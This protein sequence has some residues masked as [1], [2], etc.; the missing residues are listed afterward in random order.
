MVD[1]LVDSTY[2]EELLEGGERIVNK[3]EGV[4]KLPQQLISSAIFDSLLA[5]GGWCHPLRFRK[6][7]D[8]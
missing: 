5:S 3:F 7:L 2:F 4:E 1:T 8:V 6:L